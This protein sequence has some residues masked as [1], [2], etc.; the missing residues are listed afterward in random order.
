MSR[1]PYPCWGMAL[2]NP[3]SD[4]EKIVATFLEWRND[5]RW[6]LLGGPAAVSDKQLWTA[7]LGL[8][9]RHANSNMRANALD[10]E[11]IRLIAGTHQIRIGFERAGLAKGDQTA[12]LV[13]LPEFVNNAI[14]EMNWPNLD[15]FALDK[16]ADRLMR[17]LDAKLIPHTPI[18]NEESVQRL[19]LQIESGQ[20]A[21]H[22]AIE[23]SALAH[24]ALADFN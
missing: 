1:T 11:F 4:S 13:Y 2:T 20:S 7:W 8:G 10:V 18:P 3:I 23:R 22:D 19:E 15:R 6:L 9:S 17:V 21:D 24:I 16:E 14:S 12:W 5:E